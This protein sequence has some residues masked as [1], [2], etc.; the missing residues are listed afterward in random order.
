MCNSAAR[1]GD[2]SLLLWAMEREAPIG[3]DTPVCAAAGGHV[4]LLRI[5]KAC[6]P[7]HIVPCRAIRGA[8]WILALCREPRPTR[9][10]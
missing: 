8:H 5:L 3:F 1:R 9:S 2:E 10:S 4:H 6:A 7:S